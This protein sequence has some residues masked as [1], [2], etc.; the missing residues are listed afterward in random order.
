MARILG[1]WALMAFVSGIF[2]GVQGLRIAYLDTPS[3]VSEMVAKLN[4]EI[5]DLKL[6]LQ[7]RRELA[8]KPNRDT[9]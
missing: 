6:K 1:A 4:T 5:A 3:K 9:E 2:V 7:V 8:Q